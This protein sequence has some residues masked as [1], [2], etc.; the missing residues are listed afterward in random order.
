MNNNHQVTTFG[1]LERSL[2]DLPMTWYPGLLQIIVREAYK[3]DLFRKG[4][5]SDFVKII[6]ERIEKQTEKE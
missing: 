1:E 2:L 4:G 6:E 5:A 3:K